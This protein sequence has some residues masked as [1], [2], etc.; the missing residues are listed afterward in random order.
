MDLET[1]FIRLALDI[2]IPEDDARYLFRL[3]PKPLQEV[4]AFHD[5]LTR[6]WRYDF[7]IPIDR[8]PGDYVVI[9][10]HM[11]PLV[12]RLV[13]VLHMACRRVSEPKLSRYLH[14]LSDA[15]KHQ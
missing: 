9:G 11:F 7:G 8:L 1:I 2:N 14:R 5:R 4:P 6:L 12:D 3:L 13:R 10:T 15:M